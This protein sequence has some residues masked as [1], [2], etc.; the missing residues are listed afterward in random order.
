MQ[1]NESDGDV[2]LYVHDLP[3]VAM[4]H[5]TIEGRERL[6]NP[7]PNGESSH[8]GL[9][10][11][12]TSQQYQITIQSKT[13]MSSEELRRGRFE[14]RKAL[15][16]K[17]SKHLPVHYLFVLSDHDVFKLDNICFDDNDL[18]AIMS[19]LLNPTI[20]KYISP[21]LIFGDRCSATRTTRTYQHKSAICYKVVSTSPAVP[22]AQSTTISIIVIIRCFIIISVDA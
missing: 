20:K 10:L 11:T 15:C 16:L 6:S 3:P 8:D 2:E 1:S 7:T 18:L 22:A 21:A 13:W 5:E 9:P 17:E 14:S 19:H 4:D 12:T